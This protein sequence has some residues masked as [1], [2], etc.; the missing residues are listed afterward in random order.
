MTARPIG[1]SA[2]ST[3][4]GGKVAS[5]GDIFSRS[6]VSGHRGHRFFDDVEATFQI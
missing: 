4:A 2:P 1:I 6:K 5:G 3:M